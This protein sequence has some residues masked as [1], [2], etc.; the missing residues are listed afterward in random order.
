MSCYGTPP[1]KHKNAIPL[2]LSHNARQTG[3]MELTSHPHGVQDSMITAWNQKVFK[4]LLLHFDIKQDCKTCSDIFIE[5]DLYIAGNGYPYR[6]IITQKVTDCENEQRLKIN[7]MLNAMNDSLIHLRFP[8]VL[9][10]LKLSNCRF[11]R[12]TKC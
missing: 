10:G 9:K 11:G 1:E 3:V 2:N 7:R 4:S 5:A 12:A 6:F 8:S